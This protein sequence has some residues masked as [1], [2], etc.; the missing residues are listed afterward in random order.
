MN[1]PNTNDHNFQDLREVR[2]RKHDMGGGD[3]EELLENFV[4]YADS[5]SKVVQNKYALKKKINSH[6]PLQ[7]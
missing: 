5:S 6:F 2:N 1:R 7:F 4:V 3:T